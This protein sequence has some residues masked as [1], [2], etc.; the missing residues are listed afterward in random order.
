[1]IL[2]TLAGITINL[3]LGE[4][5]IIN[6]AQ[7]AQ[8]AIN[9]ATGNDQKT[10][11][12]LTEELNNL[13]NANS[14][15][16]SSAN[17]ILVTGIIVSPTTTSIYVGTSTETLTATIAP[18]NASNKNVTWSSSNDSVATVSSTGAVRGVAPGT[19]TITATT[20]DGNKTATC[21]VTVT[22]AAYTVGQTVTLGTGNNAEDFYVIEA[23]DAS[24]STVKLITAKCVETTNYTQSNDYDT[25]AFDEESSTKIYA[26]ASIKNLVDDYVTAMQTRTGVTLEDVET[27]EGETAVVGTK[28]RL[29]WYSEAS[30]LKTEYA[31]VLY[32]TTP[33]WNYWLGTPD[34]G[35]EP[36][37][38]VSGIRN[39]L[40]DSKPICDYGF[41]IRPVIVVSKS[42]I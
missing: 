29:M 13:T 9:Q 27:T 34:K 37:Y 16:G 22:Y 4:N 3:V 1:M 36:G 30:A 40:Y 38:R 31:E 15:G 24:T 5:G 7:N 10:I 35:S 17:S 18:E 20:A 19:A 14:S 21:N 41:G 25:V 11:N 32:G 23:S 2:I 39:L 8:N 33:P 42:N 26:D 6:Q 28:G 12:S